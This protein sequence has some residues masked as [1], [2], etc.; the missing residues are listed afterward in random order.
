MAT[1]VRVSSEPRGGCRTYLAV[2]HWP[3]PTSR[4]RH[5]ITETDP[6]AAALDDAAKHWPDDRS[7]RARLLLRLVNEGHRVVVGEAARAVQ[8]RRESVIR[9]S[10]VLTGVY[11][12]NYLAEL[13]E[14]WPQ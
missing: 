4:P 14:D 7:N 10:G 13:R 8:Q 2:L 12:D 1:A 11:G 6:V 5:V 3:M 9:T